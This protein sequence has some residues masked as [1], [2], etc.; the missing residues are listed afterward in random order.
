MN[1]SEVDCA[2]RSRISARA[3]LE[4]TKQYRDEYE[5]TGTPTGWSDPA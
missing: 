1:T 3:D 4:L 5:W 2:S